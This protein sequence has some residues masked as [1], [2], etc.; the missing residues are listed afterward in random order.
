MVR[1]VSGLAEPQLG[2]VDARGRV[3]T[4]ERVALLD[5]DLVVGVPLVL[6]RLLARVGLFD[7]G[8][9]LGVGL[10]T[11]DLCV[12]FV[13]DQRRVRFLHADILGV[14]GE[15]VTLLLGDVVGRFG[16]GDPQIFA[17]VRRV[18]ARSFGFGLG[19]LLAAVRFGKADVLGV[20]AARC[21]GVLV[22]LCLRLGIPQG[23]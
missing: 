22:D 4:G 1:R 14:A 9:L 13:S 21:A 18:P 19:D 7:R 8:V 10:N 20:A 17:R 12:G 16:P 2:V 11:V 6:R 15:I 5:G 23:Y 3:R